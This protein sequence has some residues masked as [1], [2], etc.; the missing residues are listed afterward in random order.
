MEN[1]WNHPD[2]SIPVGVVHGLRSSN[3]LEQFPVE[4]PAETVTRENTLARSVRDAEEQRASA[5]RF[6]EVEALSRV[7]LFE[8]NNGQLQLPA[9]G[10]DGT[11]TPAEGEIL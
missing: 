2:P 4:H 6:A 7:P 11:H 8:G 3:R 5:S 10:R 1:F 9:I